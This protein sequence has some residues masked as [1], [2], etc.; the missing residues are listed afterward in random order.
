MAIMARPERRDLWAITSF[1][2]PAGYRRRLDNYRVFRRE[3]AV[4]LIAVELSYGSPCELR[5]ADA[6]VLIQLRD[7]DVLWKK[8]RLLNIALRALPEE[9]DKVIWIDC[10]TIAGRDDWPDLVRRCL[11]TFPLVQTFDQLFHLPP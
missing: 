11:D 8:K 1:F 6:D 9:C 3:L 10:D 5:P 7:G 4:P 2:N